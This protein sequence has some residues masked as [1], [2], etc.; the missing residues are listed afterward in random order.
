MDR[1]VLE[2]QAVKKT[3]NRNQPNEVKV[4][5][6]V[7]LQINPGEIV[8]LLAPSGAGKS[9]LIFVVGLIEPPDAGV[10][11]IGGAEVH[12]ADDLTRTKIR[13]EDVGI[14]YQFHHLLPEFSALENIMIPQLVNGVPKAEA[15]NRALELL[16]SIGLADRDQ[17]RPAELSGGEQQR[18]SLCRS[19]ANAPRIILAD[20]PTGNLDTKTSQQVFDVLHQKVKSA[21]IGALVAT[22]NLHLARQMDRVISLQSGKL[23]ALNLVV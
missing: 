12:R 3:Y 6:G 4:L 15:R 22:H 10:I 13:R 1:P 20:E 23:K 19:L 7:E 11:K 17:H 18:V 5:K 8:G 21:N 9:T 16:A 2:V 14:V